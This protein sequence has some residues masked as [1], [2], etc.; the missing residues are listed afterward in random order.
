MHKA[1]GQ[2]IFLITQ[3][4]KIKLLYQKFQENANGEKKQF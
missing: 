4:Y 2:Q 1:Q 3:K